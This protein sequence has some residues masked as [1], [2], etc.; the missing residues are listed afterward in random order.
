MTAGS[1]LGVFVY[2]MNYPSISHLCN[3]IHRNVEWHNLNRTRVI[4]VYYW[5]NMAS[6][7]WMS[8]LFMD[9][10]T[11][12]ECHRVWRIAEMWYLMSYFKSPFKWYWWFS[13]T[14]SHLSSPL[15]LKIMKC[16]HVRVWHITV[17]LQSSRHNAVCLSKHSQQTRKLHGNRRIHVH[18]RKL[19][20]LHRLVSRLFYMNTHT[21]LV[22]I[23]NIQPVACSQFMSVNPVSE[24]TR[25][26]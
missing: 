9:Y 6:S 1:Y 24:T 23:P 20:L 22:D 2:K 26:V 12:W 16:V 15:Q 17:V 13:S 19:S 3:Q 7:K 18:S 8:E 4:W 14:L 11:V 5:Q 10:T 25:L 21:H